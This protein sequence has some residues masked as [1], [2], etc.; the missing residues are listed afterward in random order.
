MKKYICPVIAAVSA[1]KKPVL[2]GTVVALIYAGMFAGLTFLVNNVLL[3]ASQAKKAGL[4]ISLMNLVFFI[5]FYLIHSRNKRKKKMIALI[6]FLLSIIISAGEIGSMFVIPEYHKA[7]FG[8]VSA[9]VAGVKMPEKRR[10]LVKNADFYVSAEGNDENDG[11]FS[12]PFLT[13]EKAV[14]TVRSIDKSGK[15]GITVAIKAGDY[16]VDSLVFGRDDSGTKRR[17][18]H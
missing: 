17:G 11:S 7:E 15:K 12:A 2:K 3:H 16:R 18:C 1:V 14:S 13:L 4:I 5:L 8:R 9:P 6:A 10:E